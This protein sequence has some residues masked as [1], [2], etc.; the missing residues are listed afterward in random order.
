MRKDH[1]PPTP[2]RLGA[3]PWRWPGTPPLR[4]WVWTAATVAL[5]VVASLLWRGSDA[6]ATESTTADPAGVPVGAPAGSV[7]QVWSAESDP[8]PGDVVEKGRVVLAGA[9]GVRG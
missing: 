5:V 2:R 9:H 8:M 4:V 1:L 3:G 6:A 7:S